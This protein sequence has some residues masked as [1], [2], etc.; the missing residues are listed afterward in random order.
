MGCR[1]ILFHHQG[2]GYIPAFSLTFQ[3]CASVSLWL[4][5]FSMIIHQPQK[6]RETAKKVK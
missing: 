6:K 2:E 4:T 5:A 1:I 3:L